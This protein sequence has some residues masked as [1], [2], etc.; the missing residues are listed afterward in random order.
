VGRNF[1]P[2]LVLRERLSPQAGDREGD[3]HDTAWIEGVE[4]L[5][6]IEEMP[7]GS[8]VFFLEEFGIRGAAA[9]TDFFLDGG[10]ELLCLLKDGIFYLALGNSNPQ[11]VPIPTILD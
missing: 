8:G 2:C 7:H 4:A 10:E 1:S 9:F 11:S 3:L 5:Q 6:G